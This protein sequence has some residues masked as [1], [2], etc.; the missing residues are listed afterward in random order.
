MSN[1]NYRVHPFT[2]VSQPVVVNEQLTVPADSDPYMPLK[3]FPVNGTVR[4]TESGQVTEL[5]ASKD[6]HVYEG[7]ASTNYDLTYMLVGREGIGGFYRYRALL[8]FDISA[9][10]GTFTSAVLRMNMHTQTGG[11]YPNAQPHGCHRVTSSWTETGVWWSNQP[12]YNAVAEAVTN[13]TTGGFYEWDILTLFNLWHA[14]TIS[15]NGVLIAHGNENNT[16]TTRTYDSS[17]HTEG[18]P[19]L[20]VVGSGATYTE[21]PKAATVPA[22]GQYQI[23]YTRP[24][25]RFPA[26]DAG[27]VFDVTYQ[28]LGSPVRV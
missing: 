24:Y 26:A 6:A 28:G 9:L 1:N 7:N 23:N 11:Q 18:N 4:V 5:P 20:V 25:I 19:K 13:V 10:T 2:D 14:G 12:S 16:D 17:E 21:V 22:A 15:N 8:E 3:E 27:K